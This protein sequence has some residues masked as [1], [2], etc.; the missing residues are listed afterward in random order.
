[1]GWNDA[2]DLHQVAPFDPRIS[3]RAL[4]GM[5]FIP[6]GA[7]ALREKDSTRNKTLHPH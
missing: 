7:D 1:M 5:E 6:V 2:G 3:E 4:E